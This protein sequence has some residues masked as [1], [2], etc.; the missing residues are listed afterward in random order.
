M[1]EALKVGDYILSVNGRELES[2]DNVWRLLNLVTGRKFEF[3]VNSKPEKP[4][5]SVDRRAR[6]NQRY[7]AV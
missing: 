3:Q 4:M 5:G 2:N 1:G 6:S 7:R